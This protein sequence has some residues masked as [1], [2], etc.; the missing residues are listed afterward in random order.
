[1]TGALNGRKAVVTG[2]ASGI[3][4]ATVKRLARS[5]AA[6]AMVYLPGDERGAAQVLALQEEG[7]NVVG[8]TGDVTQ[9]HG[10]EETIAAA[11]H[12][13]GGIDLLV[14]SAG[15][16]GVAAVV[17]AARLD[18]ITGDIWDAVFA[19][20]VKGT[21]FCTKAAAPFLK[22]AGG[23]VV[24]VASL[25]GLDSPGSSMPYAASKAAVINLTKNL[26]RALAPEVRVN[27]VA[28]GYVDTDWTIE[29][30]AERG[31]VSKRLSLL[32]KVCSADDVADLI[33]HLGYG[34]ALTTGET[35][36]VDG[37]FWLMDA[38]N[39][40]QRLAIAADQSDET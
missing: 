10:I 8:A 14:N 26:A 22:A 40:Q 33:A 28:P 20:N 38:R 7:L 24:N 4:L 31:A 1:V 39:G 6:V 35:I 23:A 21:F 29:G 25:A 13:M 9:E 16:P 27:A 17:P 36:K 11:S 32:D 37:G 15:I 19:V 12:A 34:A 30:W 18:L 3:G 2:A 5:G